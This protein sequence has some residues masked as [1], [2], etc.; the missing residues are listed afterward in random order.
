MSLIRINSH[1]SR[2]QLIVFA[3]A[4]LLVF[5][6]LGLAQWLKARPTLAVVWWFI[7]PV[8]PVLG[9]LSWEGLRRLYVGLSYATYP[10]GFVVSSVVL[11]LIYYAVLTPIGLI[12]RL[13]GHDALE[14]RFDS[15]AT[16]YWHQRPSPPSPESYF[17]QH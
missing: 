11:G 12:L 9:A 8:G 6:A 16:S 10:L 1:P 7:A 14:R 5:G 13:C 3:L 4:W 2:R 15:R 17:R